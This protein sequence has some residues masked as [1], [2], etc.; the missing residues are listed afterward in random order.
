MCLYL[1][2]LLFL[3]SMLITVGCSG[4]NFS[5][6]HFPYMMPVQ[7]GNLITMREYKQLKIGMT[8]EEASY[9][10]GHPVTQFLFA[11]NRWDFVYQS[12]TNNDLKNSYDVT[13]FFDKNNKISSINKS[14]E[15]PEK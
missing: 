10:V 1:K 2:R 11:E 6:W 7:Q 3:C 9:L 5:N 4:V 8:K 15:L 12:Y 14:G 13:I